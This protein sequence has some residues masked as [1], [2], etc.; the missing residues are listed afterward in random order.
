MKLKIDGSYVNGTDIGHPDGKNISHACCWGRFPRGFIAGNTLEERK[1][2]A[3]LMVAA[4]E[5]YEAAIVQQECGLPSKVTMYDEDGCE[6][7]LWQHPDGR[8]WIFEYRDGDHP[9]NDQDGWGC[10]GLWAVNGGF[11]L[12]G[13]QGW[14]G[15][16]QGPTKA[17]ARLIAVAPKMYELIE[18]LSQSYDDSKSSHELASTLYDLRCMALRLLDKIE[19]GGE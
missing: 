16:Y 5:L 3:R 17:N 10:N 14:D 4:P 6:G 7:W 13:G 9:L 19:G 8:E 1:H 2:Y 12:G 18:Y 15:T 11:I